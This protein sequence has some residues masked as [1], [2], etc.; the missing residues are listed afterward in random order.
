M[1]H[2]YETYLYSSVDTKIMFEARIKQFFL[3]KSRRSVLYFDVL[4]VQIFIQQNIMGAMTSSGWQLF[5]KM[6]A[7]KELIKEVK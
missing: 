6:L 7:G 1:L 4:H 2:F 5:S 3:F